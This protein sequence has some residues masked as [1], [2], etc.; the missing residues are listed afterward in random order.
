MHIGIVGYS[1]NR[2][3]PIAAHAL[4]QHAMQQL[5]SQ[6]APSAQPTDI[7]II[8]GLTNIGIPKIAYQIADLHGYHTVGISAARALTVNCGIYAVDQ[9]II[10]G[11]QFGDE[12]ACFIATIDY[13]IRVGGGRQS[14][15]EV[16]LFK[17]KCKALGRDM[18]AYL[19][20]H[21]LERLI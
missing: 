1:S 18:N 16:E 14:H 5:I 20:E 2:I 11:E 9:Q 8:S 21:A 6:H 10:V 7:H 17:A 15:H 4:L 19:V 12:S 13:L 3:D